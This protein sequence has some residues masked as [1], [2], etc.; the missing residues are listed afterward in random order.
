MIANLEVCDTP[1][2][3]AH[4]AA[5]IIEATTRAK[6]DASLLIATGN[7]PMLTYAEL[8]RRDLDMS[9]VCAVQLDDYLGID[10]EDPRSLYGWLQRS[11][12]EPLGVTRV[13]RFDPLAP[14]PQ[15]AC[16]QYAQAVRKL[17]GIDLAVLG[18][19]PNGHLGFNEPP[20]NASAP[21]RSVTLSEASLRSNASY[22]R[23]KDV[24]K[25]ALTAGMDVILAARVR[26]LL[27]TGAH[28]RDILRRVLSEPVTP[29]V[30]AS[31]LREGSLTVVADREAAC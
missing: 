2:T 4:R 22:W 18:L 13:L 31:Y 3:V 17:G 29:E 15:L 25:S 20:S 14:D 16:E 27:V 24:P 6:P 28:K 5:D 7:T 23:G 9:R 1:E 8:A 26:L 11:F 10:D 12:V 19:G 21:T 30:P